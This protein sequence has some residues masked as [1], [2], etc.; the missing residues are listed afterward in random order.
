[1]SL[2]GKAALITGA[3]SGIGRALATALLQRS[4]NVAVADF[5]AENGRKA[6]SELNATSAA[7]SRALFVECD[8]SNTTSLRSAF[9]RTVSTFGRLDIVCNNAGIAVE[10]P[11]DWK[12]TIDTNLSAVI[13]GTYLAIEHMASRGGGVVI[14]VASMGGLI[15]MSVS[16]V[17]CAAKHGV[18][19][20]TKSVWGYAKKRGVRVNAICPTMV[21]TPML[22]AG[23]AINPA[24]KKYAEEAGTV[25]MDVVIGGMLELLENETHN[26][27]IMRV[28]LQK[29]V[30]FQ[31]Y[32][33][34]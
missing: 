21:R 30:D 33:K 27:A 31:K 34:M 22:E 26:G 28:T 2:R 3:A 20:F 25:E 10:H 13:D 14:N 32:S 11:D 9:E 1:M 17:Y 7:S 5:N 29:G 19:G 4:C 16:P 15:P 24:F 6:E 18:L 8:V 23:M 12:S